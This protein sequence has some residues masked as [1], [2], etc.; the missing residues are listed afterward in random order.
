M[1][2]IWEEANA[3]GV[4]RTG[5]PDG[6]AMYG[7]VLANYGS[8]TAGITPIRRNETCI[9]KKGEIV[10]MVVDRDLAFGWH[11]CEEEGAQMLPTGNDNIIISNVQIRGIDHMTNEVAA[12]RTKNYDAS[13]KAFL[14]SAQVDVVGAVYQYEANVDAEFGS[15]GVFKGNPISN[16]QLFVTKYIEKCF[17][18]PPVPEPTGRCRRE[19]MDHIS[20]REQPACFRNLGGDAAELGIELNQ[21]RQETLDWA[22]NGGMYENQNWVI[23][24][25]DN[26]FHVNKVYFVYL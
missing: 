8:H 20:R 22:A 17:A 9:D 5:L 18:P 21:I 1:S 12:L 19:T 16:A 25:G 24:G 3:Q 11:R 7:I 2:N 15:H 6:S 14:P 4:K 13:R 26:M 23:C 10:G